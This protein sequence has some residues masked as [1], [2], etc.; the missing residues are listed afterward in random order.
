MTSARHAEG[1]QF[2][3]G[4]VY[5]G[6]EGGGKGGREDEEEHEQG[7]EQEEGKEEEEEQE[8]EEQ[9]KGRERLKGW[10]RRGGAR[11]PVWF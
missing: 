7:E 3:P 9:G 8:Q 5:K 10:G 1:R 11:L 6:R 2:D 4:Q